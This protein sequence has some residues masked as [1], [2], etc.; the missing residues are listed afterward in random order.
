MKQ[1]HKTVALWIVMILIFAVLFKLFDPGS[2]QRR[3]INFTEFNKAVEAHKVKE[4]TIRGDT[5]V[6]TFTDAQPDGRKGFEVVIDSGRSGALDWNTYFKQNFV[7][8]NY[9]PT[10]K[11]PFWQQ[12]LIS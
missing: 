7:H 6:G 4:V 9:E 2:R 10:E 3:E 11:T 8:N 12:I 5:L 1:S